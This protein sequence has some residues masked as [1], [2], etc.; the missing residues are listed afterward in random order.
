MLECRRIHPDAIGSHT[1]SRRY[2]ICRAADDGSIWQVWKLAPG[3]P[4][5]APLDLHLASEE[6]AKARAEEDAAR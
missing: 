1:I 4:W 3:G 5:F 6:A 2:S